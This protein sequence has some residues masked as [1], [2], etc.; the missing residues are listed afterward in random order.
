MGIELFAPVNGLILQT[1]GVLGAVLGWFAMTSIGKGI[2]GR[3]PFNSQKKA[4]KN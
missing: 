3:H 1:I 4:E 2:F